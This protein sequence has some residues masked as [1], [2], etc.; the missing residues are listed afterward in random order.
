MNTIAG[1]FIAAVCALLLIAGA[2]AVWSVWPDVP[3]DDE[4]H[5][6]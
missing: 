6:L 4:V 5:P 2:C 3:D 1:I